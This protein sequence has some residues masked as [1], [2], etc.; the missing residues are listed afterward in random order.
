M[1][2]MKPLCA[3]TILLVSDPLARCD[4]QVG[5][6]YKMAASHDSAD[7]GASRS[8]RADGREKLTRCRDGPYN[9]RCSAEKSPPIPLREDSHQ[10]APWR[11]TYE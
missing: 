6:T 5:D 11:F 10:R 8:R 3:A 7:V 2:K 4:F 9:S 1:T